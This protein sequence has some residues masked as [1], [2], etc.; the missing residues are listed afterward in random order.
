MASSSLTKN[1]NKTVKD[2]IKENGIWIFSDIECKADKKVCYT[3]TSLFQAFQDKEFVVLLQNDANTKL[4]REI[5]RNIIKSWLHRAVM[6]TPVLPCPDIIKWITRRI[7]HQ[8]RSILNIEGKVV[9]SYKPSMINQM[10]HLKEATIKVSS[11]WL[12]Q[13]SESVDML[14]LLKGWWSE[15]NFKRKTTTIEWKT[16]K[17]KKMVQ[18]IVIFLSRVFGRKD[19][20]TF[21]DQWIPIIYQI[22][23]SGA[24]LNWGELISSNLDNQLKKV[25]KD[26]QFYMSTYLMA[27]MC[28]N[29]EF[30]SLEWKWESSLPLVHVDCKMLWE[31]KYKEYYDQICNNFFPTLYQTL[32]GE[33]TP[34][35]SPTG[36]EIV[37]ELGD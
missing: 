2:P 11:N 21:P 5:Y 24:T 19:G 37:K 1:L 17:F 16:S 9:A 33:E 22:I 6:K 27:V 30:P 34:C 31:N 18:I 35:L 3:W 36:Q 32:F 29:I 4:S 25:H 8:H 28:A 20:S 12:K 26:H 15:G 7:D 14:T 23:T 13:K 10:Y